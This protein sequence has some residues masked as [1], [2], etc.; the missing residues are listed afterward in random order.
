MGMT[1]DETSALDRAVAAVIRAEAAAQKVSWPALASLSGVSKSSMSNYLNEVSSPKLSTLDAISGALGLD[2][3]EVLARARERMA[4]A[5][6]APAL[7]PEVSDTAPLATPQRAGDTPPQG[8]PKVVQ[9]VRRSA[10]SRGKRT[11]ENN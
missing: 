9:P 3:L 6:V 5:T 4:R 2:L 11:H 10:S 1:T 7:A 8:G